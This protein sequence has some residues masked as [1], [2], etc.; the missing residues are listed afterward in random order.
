MIELK[1]SSGS[2]IFLC[3]LHSYSLTRVAFFVEGT[4]MSHCKVIAIANQKGGIGKTTTT[5]NLGIG[6]ANQGKKVLLVDADSQGDL[7]AALGWGNA[8]E[9]RSRNYRNITKNSRD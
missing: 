3:L 9:I 4:V 7:T 2:F 8:D 1:S 5:I 6:L